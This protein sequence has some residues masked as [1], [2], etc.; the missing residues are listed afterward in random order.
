MFVDRGIGGEFGVE[1]GGDEIS[2]L[3]EDG[4]AGVFGEDFE[5]VAGAFDDG[6]ADEDHFHRPRFEFARTEEDIAGNLATVGIAENGHVHKAKG[7]LR[8]ILDFGGE[9]DCP[10][11]SA[12]NGAARVCEITD[13]VVET[14]FLEKL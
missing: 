3:H 1:G 9:Q 6:T 5:G 4:L 7:G 13:R 10:S 14:F 11:A 12:E 2:A 8:G